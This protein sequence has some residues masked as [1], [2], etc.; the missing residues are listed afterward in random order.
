[1]TLTGRMEGKVAVIT[2][3]SSGIGRATAIRLAREG[4]KLALGARRLDQLETLA[5]EIE[6][7]GGEALAVETDV[8]DRDS[9]RSLVNA[10][11]ETFGTVDVAVNNAAIIGPLMPF[12][13]IPL[14]Q[15]RS[16]MSI[17]LDGVFHCMQA[18]VKVMQD[19][20]GGAIVNVGSVNSFIGAPGASA[21][22]T[23]KHAL[24]GL[25]RSAAAEL[26][27]DN[28]RVNIVCPGLVQ[29]EMQDAI[30]DLATGGQPEGFE[31][32]FIAR[33]PQGRMADPMEIAQAILWAASDEASFLTGSA[34]TPDGGI[35]AC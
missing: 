1:M 22:V 11:V 35:M 28:I 24:L 9:A 15:W 8:A 16:L 33:T 29:T 25:T 21:Y 19:H 5:T 32:P 20:G 34:I 4:A 23:S 18:Q 3:A 6:T 30:A 7:S 27:A 31:N 14:E 2:G 10:A 13:D 17:N 12:A 26:A